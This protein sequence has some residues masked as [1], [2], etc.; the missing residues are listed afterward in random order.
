MFEFPFDG[1]AIVRRSWPAFR[2]FAI[3]AMFGVP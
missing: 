2:H 3:L 1:G